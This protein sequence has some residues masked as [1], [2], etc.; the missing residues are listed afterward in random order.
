[1]DKWYRGRSRS[2]A[3]AVQ[4]HD[5]GGPIVD[6]GVEKLFGLAQVCAAEDKQQQVQDSRS[7]QRSLLLI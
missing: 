6:T 7:E 5:P 2:L 1:M 3:I 4:F